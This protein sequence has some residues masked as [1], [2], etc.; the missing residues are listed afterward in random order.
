MEKSASLLTLRRLDLASLLRFT[1][2]LAIAFA[3]GAVAL[4]VLLRSA[5]EIPLVSPR[6]PD[7]PHAGYLLVIQRASSSSVLAIDPAGASCI[8]LAPSTTLTTTC[9]LATITDAATIGAAAEGRLNTEDAPAFEAIVWRA[10]LSQS[11]TDCA[12]SGL[13]DRHLA[14]C[15]AAV[16]RGEVDISDAGLSVS[17]RSSQAP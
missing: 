11:Q 8:M 13:L 9:R 1:A 16:R 6:T 7:S 3:A 4:G 10:V 5:P 12:S 15:Q 14:I 2:G 17:V